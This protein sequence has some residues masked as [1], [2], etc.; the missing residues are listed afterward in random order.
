MKILSQIRVKWIAYAVELLLIC[1]IQ[2]TPNLLPAFLGVK[3]LLLPV[4][5]ISIAMF[6]GETTAMWFGVVAGMLMDIT[7]SSVFG[8]NTLM[9]MIICYICGSLVVFLM[10]NN[11]VTAM[12]LGVGGLLAM[13]LMRWLCFYVLWGD[14]KIWYYLYAIML[15]QI[16]Y[17]AVIMPIAFYFNRA[18]ASHL[19]DEE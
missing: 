18:I 17:S 9:L 7:S 1:I 12:V 4:F 16:V 15:P 3:P 5:A 11:I 10:R 6:E 13:E 8:V 2:S 14:T 19:S